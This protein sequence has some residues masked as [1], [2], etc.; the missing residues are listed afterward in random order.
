MI[1][2]KGFRDPDREV[3]T[4]PKCDAARRVPIGRV[5]AVSRL[6]IDN[7]ALPLIFLRRMKKTV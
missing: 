5:R 1:R 6:V 3:A 7:T 4:Q 2:S